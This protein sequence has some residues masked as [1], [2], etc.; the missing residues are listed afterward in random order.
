MILKEYINKE[1]GK[2]VFKIKVVPNSKE[3]TFF[4]VM[5]N[6]ILKIKLRSLPE[7][8]K[9]NKELIDY[10]ANKLE[11]KKNK[12]KILS[13]LTDKIKLIQVDFL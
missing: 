3:T 4:S 13:G 6:G 1:N 7:K 8:G 2:R 10:F 12:I 11:V 5:D 9:A